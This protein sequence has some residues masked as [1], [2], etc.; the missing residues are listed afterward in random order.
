M[1]Q[2]IT[3]LWFLLQV[4]NCVQR[5]HQN[6]LENLPQFFFLLAAGG[7]SHPCI[8]AGAGILDTT[9]LPPIYSSYWGRYAVQCTAVQS[10]HSFKGGILYNPSTPA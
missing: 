5:A 8:A 1:E 9:V 6:T 7:L 4:F 2:S 10:L 3:E